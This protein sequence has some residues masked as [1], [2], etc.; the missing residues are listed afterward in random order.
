MTH[1]TAMGLLSFSG[2]A[3]EQ[4]TG[5]IMNDITFD[6][7]LTRVRRLARRPRMTRLGV[8]RAL[9]A[10]ASEAASVAIF[11]LLDHLKLNVYPRLPLSESA[12]ET[13]LRGWPWMTR[14]ASRSVRSRSLLSL[15]RRTRLLPPRPCARAL[16]A[17]GALQR[18]SDH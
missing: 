7:L 13:L 12:R 4:F 15:W 14:S 1:T 3:R 11:A 17:T 5:S 18:L 9:R 16:S 8:R 6:E 2:T 10:S